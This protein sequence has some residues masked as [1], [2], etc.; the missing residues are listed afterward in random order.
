MKT[1]KERA[2]VEL[3]TFVRSMILY[4]SA[5][6][7]VFQKFID[8]YLRECFNENGMTNGKRFYPYD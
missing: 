5:D 2:K 7:E 4:S 8:K 1:P 6:I 3:D